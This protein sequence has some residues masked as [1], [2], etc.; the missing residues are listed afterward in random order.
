MQTI[1]LL[2]RIFI[3]KQKYTLGF[4]TAAISKLTVLVAFAHEAL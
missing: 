1:L 3:E 2:Y 4:D